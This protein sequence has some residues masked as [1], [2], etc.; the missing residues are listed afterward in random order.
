MPDAIWVDRDD[1]LPALAHAL[2][3]QSSIGLDTEFLRERTFF[4]KLCLL[5]LA[6]GGALWCVDTL[7]CSLAALVPALT[8][9]GRR[10]RL[11]PGRLNAAQ[12]AAE[13]V[14]LALIRQL[15]AFGE[16]HE[17]E[18]FIQLI[19]RVLERF[20]D[21]RGVQHGLMDGRNVGRTEISRLDPGLGAGGFRAPFRTVLAFGALLPFLPFLPFLTLGA[22][23]PFRA[24][25]RA[26]GRQAFRSF[27]PFGRGLRLGVAFG[28]DRGGFF[29]VGFAKTAGGIGFSFRRFGMVGGSF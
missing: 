5:Q 2:A 15:L 21:L 9:V 3:A 20:G 4:P 1:Q 12:R 29:R 23:R 19:H 7:R 14:H 28:L 11:M 8:A 10:R 22:L 26:Q 24:L 18:N 6:A 13:F 16:F 17:F 27:R 25:L